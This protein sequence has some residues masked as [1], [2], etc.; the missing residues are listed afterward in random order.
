MGYRFIHPYFIFKEQEDEVKKESDFKNE[1]YNEIRN[2]FPG[3]EVVPNDAGYLQGF[4]DA[5]VYFPNGRYFLLEG[6]RTSKSARQ[7]NQ[8][9]Y[10]NQS[11]LRDNATFVS[12]ENKNKVLDELERRYNE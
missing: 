3:A 9:Y 12:P 10:V 1:L 11:P 5:T 4:P 2:R 7:P 6:K 8:D